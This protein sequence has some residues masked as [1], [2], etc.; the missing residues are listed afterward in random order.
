MRQYWKDYGLFEL[1]EQHLACQVRSLLKTGKL[2]KLK[3]EGLK[4]Q[5]EQ[6][7][8][9]SVKAEARELDS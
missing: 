4:R 6:I 9:A 8:V 7:H 2:S 5:F 3:K 1:K